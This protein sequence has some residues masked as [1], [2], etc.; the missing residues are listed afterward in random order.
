MQVTRGRPGFFHQRSGRF[1]SR[2]VFHA[3]LIHLIFTRYIPESETS[4]VDG[5]RFTS[6]T[7]D[8][9]ALEDS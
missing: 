5:F 8:V 2:G 4:V 9:F 6:V 7:D 1:C 3:L